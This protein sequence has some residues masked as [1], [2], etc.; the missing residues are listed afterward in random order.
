MSIMDDNSIRIIARDALVFL[1]SILFWI[2]IGCAFAGDNAIIVIFLLPVP[3][4]LA[5]RA[6][7]WISKKPDKG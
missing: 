3:T 2:F 6:I 1:F 4:Y 5:F 7:L